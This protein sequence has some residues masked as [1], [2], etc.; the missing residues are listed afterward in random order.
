ML[1]SER[2]YH[3]LWLNIVWSTH[4]YTQNIVGMIWRNR[5]KHFGILYFI[6]SVSPSSSQRYKVCPN[7]SGR[8][9]NSHCDWEDIAG[10]R[11]GQASAEHH[12][13][14]VAVQHTLV[15][16]PGYRQG[17]SDVY[18]FMGFPAY[19][20]KHVKIQWEHFRFWEN[21]HERNILLSVCCF[22]VLFCWHGNYCMWPAMIRL[23]HPTGLKRGTC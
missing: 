17:E 20:R 1:F 11:D 23:K 4:N 22:H 18:F 21:E 13:L 14:A 7:E 2:P 15:W 6:L 3:Q 5:V 19:T 9:S 10:R 16:V 8:Q 12:L